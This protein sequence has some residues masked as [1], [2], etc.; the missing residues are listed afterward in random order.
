M[1]KIAWL[2]C[3][4]LVFRGSAQ[5][6]VCITFDDL[7]CVN[8]KNAA[9][10]KTVLSSLV[11]VL[12]EEK[13]P[14]IGFV[15]EYKLYQGKKLD[16]GM[17]NTLDFWLKNNF[18]LGNHTWSHISIDNATVKQY[19]AD[20]TK[21][22]KITKPLAQKHG[23][24]Y[25]YFRH[26]QLRTGATMSYKKAL[27]SAIVKQGY[28]IAPVTM[29]NDEYI[30][31]YCYAKALEQKDS[32]TMRVVRYHYLLYMRSIVNFYERLS[33]DFLGYN[34]PHILLLHANELNAH[35]LPELLN[36]FKERDYTFITLEEALKDKAY[37]QAEAV[38]N[39][40]L[41]W[42]QRWMVAAG[43]DLTEQPPATEQTQE[44]FA[45]YRHDSKRVYPTQTF[46]GDAKELEKI[47]T[48]ISRFSSA[49]MQGQTEELV[50]LYTSDAGLLPGNGDIV[51]GE[52]AIR[53]FWK[54]P[55]G[56]KILLHV[57][58]P[59]EIEV[60]ENTAYDHGYFEGETLFA[61]GKKSKWYGKYVIA[62]K[63]VN[64]EWKIYLDSWSRL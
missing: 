33:K 41:S 39:R 56:Q 19:A 17:V 38:Y 54:I 63:K 30:Y 28:T 25:R 10:A 22:E 40:G 24:P 50:K 15:N 43:K 44:L 32:V 20:I 34:V 16:T 59:L 4:L 31:A 9:A 23:K 6:K 55:Q 35:C 45:W 46:K 42:I 1:R 61:D 52:A 21:G 12:Q 58:T 48:N 3:C 29:D 13:I 2:I 47:K 36:I 49:Y 64:G 60:V 26:T 7:P 57:V 14:A 37:T 11:N 51:K 53:K 62:W 5:N 18:E 8:C 27:D